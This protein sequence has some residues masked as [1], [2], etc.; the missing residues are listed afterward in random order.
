VVYGKINRLITVLTLNNE[1]LTAFGC[2]DLIPPE[3]A[4]LKRNGDGV[5]IGCYF[6]RQTWQLHCERGR[7][8]GVFGNCSQGMLALLTNH[9]VLH[10]LIIQQFSNSFSLLAR[11]P[12]SFRLQYDQQKCEFN[13]SATKL[14]LPLFCIQTYRSYCKRALNMQLYSIVN[15]CARLPK[16]NTAQIV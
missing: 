12:I 14:I 5:A 2:S 16:R 13:D 15:Q 1:F 10:S 3:D 6:S 11:K 7:W 4:W 9:A 8:T